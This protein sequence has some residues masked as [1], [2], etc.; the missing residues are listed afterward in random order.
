MLCARMRMGLCVRLCAD[1]VFW[2]HSHSL[3]T[4]I[5]LVSPKN[6]LQDLLENLGFACKKSLSIVADFC[7][8]ASSIRI[9]IGLAST[10]SRA[11]SSHKAFWISDSV[12]V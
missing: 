5:K 4:K 1:S 12:V 7:A 2:L 3:K 11:S 6:L 8:Y 10:T 9:I